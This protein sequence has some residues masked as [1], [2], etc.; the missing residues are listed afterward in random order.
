MKHQLAAKALKGIE[1]N[2]VARRNLDASDKSYNDILQAIGYS[3]QMSLY[4]SIFPEVQTITILSDA[5]F[6]QMTWLERFEYV[7]KLAQRPLSGAKMAEE[8]AARDAEFNELT[9][10]EKHKK[11]APMLSTKGKE[12]KVIKK[13][14]ENGINYYALPSWVDGNI[15]KQEYRDL[16]VTQAEDAE[17]GFDNEDNTSESA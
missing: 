7:I 9:K 13:V 14:V 15:L 6:L 16:L 17:D 4:P 10:R 2:K 1:D 3:T 12:G 8:M 11:L 5:D